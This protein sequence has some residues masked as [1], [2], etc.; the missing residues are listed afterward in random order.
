MATFTVTNAGVLAVAGGEVHVDLLDP[1]SGLV[2]PSASAPLDLL[3]SESSTGEIRLPSG[4]QALGRRF[5]LLE[6]NGTTLASAPVQ[7]FD[8]P[9]PPSLNFPAEAAS[10]SQPM[11]LSVNNATNPNGQHL[12]YEFEIYLDDS[13]RFLVGSGSG[14]AEGLNTTT[15]DS[16][17]ALEENHRYVW[18]ARARDRFAASDWMPPASFFSDSANDAPRAPSLSSPADESEV[19]TRTPLLT[20]VNG[21][22]PEGAALAYT[23]EVYADPGLSELVVT[24][25]PIPE[26][27]GATSA[28]LV[29]PLDEDRTYFWRAR[30]TDGEL[31]SDWMPPAS[32][33]VNTENHPPTRP[34]PI[35]P[36]GSDAVTLTPELSAKAGLDPEGDAVTHRFE[37]DVSPDFDTAALQAADGLFAA[38]EQVSFT[39]PVALIENAVYFWRVRASDGVASSEWSEVAS[40]RVDAANEPPSVPRASSPIGGA[41]VATTTP[42]L[43]IVN[44][45]DPEGD[46]LRYDVEVY[47]E[48]TTSLT[49]SIGGLREGQGQTSWVVSPRLAEDRSYQWRVRA[50]DGE[51]ASDWSQAE[52][53]LVNAMNAKPEAPSLVSPGE[54]SLVSSLPVTLHVTNGT[55]PDG[56]ALTYRFELYGDENLSELV[57][58]SSEI[59]EATDGTSW[60][61]SAALEENHVYFWR[62]RAFDGSLESSWMPTARFRLSLVNEAPTPPALVSPEDGAVVGETRPLLEVDNAIDPD[63]DPLHYVFEVYADAEQSTLVAASPPLETVEPR[64]SWRVSQDLVENETYYWRARATDGALET[65]SADVFELD[66]NAVDEAP[67][68]PIPLEPAN[69]ATVTTRAPGLVVENGASPDGRP[70]VYR[71]ELYDGNTLVAS[72]DVPEGSSE[73]RWDVPLDLDPGSTYSWRSRAVDD[74][75]LSSEWTELSSFTV[76]LPSTG[77]PPEWSE[78]F[79]RFT[80]GDVPAGWRLRPESGDPVFEVR[81]KRLVNRSPSRAAFVFEG[82]GEAYGWRNYRLEGVL[83]PEENGR[84]STGECGLSAGVVFY[85]SAQ[86]EYRLEV[87]GP[88]CHHPKA[89]LVAASAAG[90]RVLAERELEEVEDDPISF[91]VEL[92][93]D[94]GLTSIVAELRSE[95]ESV[96]L[97]AEDSTEPLRAGTIGAWSDY[98]IASWDDFHV[99]AIP[100]YESGI[101]GDENGD[102][103]CD[104]ESPACV[105]PVDVCLDAGVVPVSC[106]G[107]C[108]HSGP[109]AC[110]AKHSYFVKKKTGVLFVETPSV[111][112][113][114]YRFRV[115]LHP[116][117]RAKEP[118]IRVELDSGTSF[119]VAA[120]RDGEDDVHGDRDHGD[121]GDDNDDNDDN[122]PF[123]WSHGFDVELPSG[124]TTFRIRSLVK[125]TVFIEAFRL[126]PSCK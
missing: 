49:A 55:D 100:G 11:R 109:T 116:G 88:R 72:Q 35:A 47:D 32:F 95:E 112:A 26:G 50:T 56:D 4:G 14:I 73:T 21:V 7:L 126:E 57:E 89:R 71:F 2:T 90:E 13:L 38:G 58:A 83:I 102:G 15:W 9:A 101:S 84:R 20:V 59:P 30:A 41:I 64:T 68:A 113:G 44:S 81:S 10:A 103:V 45:A 67:T 22:D 1:V 6:A 119:D 97:S 66:V 76:E 85:S 80:N 122:G 107:D 79:H 96:S 52:S 93:N 69:G 118:V 108:G 42:A 125:S 115:L 33:R 65:V 43:V 31:D 105:D 78:D 74:R 46:A 27:D 36:A 24:L 104:V 77:C 8:I 63:G 54:A 120:D 62:A 37:I 99:R 70:L 3:P 124:V 106:S 92:T 121:R 19:D 110:G 17:L 29:A 51:L 40:F 111:E 5:V 12:V 28:P 82:S 25:A 114:T 60:E 91:G 61:M 39:P 53:F 23:F 75:G 94:V 87:E 16:P 34:E 48:T 98:V 18:R 117:E 123:S 86:G